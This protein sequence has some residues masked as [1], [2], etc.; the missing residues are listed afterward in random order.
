MDPR[1]KIVHLGSYR[2]LHE[3]AQPASNLNVLLL[4]RYIYYHPIIKYMH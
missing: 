2:Q 1:K 3:H 4:L